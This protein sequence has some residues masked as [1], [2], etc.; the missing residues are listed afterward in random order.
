MKKG[1]ECVDYL[2]EP[3]AMT[4]TSSAVATTTISASSMVK[5]R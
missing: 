1:R 4:A 3:K 5:A 2:R